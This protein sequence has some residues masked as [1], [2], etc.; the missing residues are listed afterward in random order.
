VAGRSVV[1]GADQGAKT[2]ESVRRD[3]AAVVGPEAVAEVQ[4]EAVGGPDR[5]PTLDERGLGV[6]Q[7]A[8]EVEYQGLHEA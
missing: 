6:H 5:S 4:G 1:A 7:Q 2:V 8:V 3:V